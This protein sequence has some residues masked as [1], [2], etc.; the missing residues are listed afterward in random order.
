MQ[1]DA[2][3][4]LCF[5]D[6]LSLIQNPSGVAGWGPCWALLP[7]TFPAHLGSP[8]AAVP[9][10]TPGLGFQLFVFQSLSLWDC[11]F[12]HLSCCKAVVEFFYQ[13]CEEKSLPRHGYHRSPH[14]VA[15]EHEW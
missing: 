11:S 2:E 1:G 9:T 13:A 7:N 8:S 15:L 6:Q 10:C 4:K 14:P 5:I 3:G 12:N